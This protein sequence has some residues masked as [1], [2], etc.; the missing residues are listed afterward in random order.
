M[1]YEDLMQLMVLHGAALEKA[2]DIVAEACRA[3]DYR[4][5]SSG[6]AGVTVKQREVFMNLI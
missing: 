5:P 2:L 6:W 3:G 1:I 4:S